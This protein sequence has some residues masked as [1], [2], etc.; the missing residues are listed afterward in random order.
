MDDTLMSDDGS[1]FIDT[2]KEEDKQK[3]AAKN[4]YKDSVRLF[5]FFYYLTVHY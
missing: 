3:K 4:K 2:D 5:Y 1:K